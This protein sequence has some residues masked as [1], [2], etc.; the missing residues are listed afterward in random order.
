VNVRSDVNKSVAAFTA[1]QRIYDRLPGGAVYSAHVDMQLA[2]FALSSGQA[3]E[4][5]R[6][7]DRAIPVVRQAENAALLATL[8]LIKA[9]ALD[10]AGRGTEAEVLRRDTAGLA[11]YG[12]GSTAQVRARTSEI[13]ALARRGNRG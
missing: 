11:T 7:T 4:A 2:A 1:A 9:E 3:G 6:R 12:F 13:S 8:L 5:L 10:M